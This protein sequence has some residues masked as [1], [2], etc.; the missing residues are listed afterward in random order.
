[1][2]VDILK[3]INEK[4]RYGSALTWLIVIIILFLVVV[5][6]QWFRKGAVKDPDLSYNLPPW[7][8]WKLRQTKLKPPQEI[9]KEQP[10]IT[11]GLVFD[12]SVK[13]DE[14]ARGRNY[15]NDCA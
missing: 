4:R 11:K 13:L 6:V 2:R 7:T 3:E 5:G 9:S 1:M 12:T 10:D 14:E 8:E 15:D